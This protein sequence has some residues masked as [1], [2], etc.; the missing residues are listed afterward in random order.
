MSVTISGSG[1]IIKQV[2]QTVKTDTFSSTAANAWTDVTGLSVSITPTNASNKILVI[3]SV[4]GV[5]ISSNTYFRMV[6]GST[7]IGV[8]DAAGSRSQV[9]SSN[10][11]SSQAGTGNSMLG[12]TFQY[13][14]S[15]ATTSATTYKIQF[16][17]DSGTTLVNRTPNDTDALYVGR[18]ISTITVYEVAYA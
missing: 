18:S 8:G 5:N 16:I 13:L 7:A 1:Q 9:S 10:F 14:D 3:C 12:S 11:Y 4:T 17:T 6:R 2:I 15:P